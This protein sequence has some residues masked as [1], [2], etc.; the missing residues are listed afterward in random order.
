MAFSFISV[1]LSLLPGIFRSVTIHLEG[2]FHFPQKTRERSER[3]RYYGLHQVWHES[4]GDLFLCHNLKGKTIK[5]GRTHPAGIMVGTP[6][7]VTG[8]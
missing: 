1:W 3:K 4:E 7:P 8:V 6:L 5:E 2:L